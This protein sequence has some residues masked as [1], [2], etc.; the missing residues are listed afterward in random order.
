MPVMDF[1]EYQP[2]PT[3]W[4]LPNGVMRLMSAAEIDRWPRDAVRLWC[5]EQARYGL[6]TVELVDWLKEQIGDRSA[7]EI[8]A[9]SGDLCFHLNIPGTD[10]KVQQA[11]PAVA[12]YYQMSRQPVVNYPAWIE[13]L[14]AVD[15]VKRHQPQVVVASWVTHWVTSRERPKHN[16]GSIYGVKEHA[17]LA[18]GCESIF[19]GNRAVHEYKPLLLKHRFEEFTLPFLRS[20]AKYPE[21][22]RVFIFRP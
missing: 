17:I 18:A 22:D 5:A 7:I 9:G 2:M 12:L 19:I 8:G 15:T 6:P 3:V 1:L 20:R 4:L 21:L 11:N 14:D 13:Q 10:S 16:V